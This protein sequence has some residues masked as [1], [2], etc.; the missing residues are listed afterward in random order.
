MIFFFFLLLDH[1][2]NIFHLCCIAVCNFSLPVKVSTVDTFS[3]A[4][5]HLLCYYTFSVLNS[6]NVA[7]SS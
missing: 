5:T 7:D 4:L 1:L 2:G 6:I 3:S